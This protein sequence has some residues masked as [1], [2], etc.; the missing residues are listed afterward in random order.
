MAI[1]GL[2]DDVDIGRLSTPAAKLT[3]GLGGGFEAIQGIEDGML[4]DG[5]TFGGGAKWTF[6]KADS[7]EIAK[8]TGEIR[9]KKDCGNPS[10]LKLT[11]KAKD[12]TFKGK[13]TV[14][15]VQGGKLK[16]FTANVTGVMV[17]GIGYGTATIKKI[18][19]ANVTIVAD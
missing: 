16:K 4:P 15:A 12:G 1:E 8:K 10:G 11:Y 19:S 14:Y 5:F 17:G 13:F 2:G 9:T 7:V 3:F 18:G 6:R